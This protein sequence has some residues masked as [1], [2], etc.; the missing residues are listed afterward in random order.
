M[1]GGRPGS[2]SSWPT[3]TMPTSARRRPRPP[4]STPARSAG[5]C[6]A[7]AAT[8]AARI[9]TLDPLVLAALR[10]PEQRAAADIVGYAG[11][12]L[13]PPARRRAGQRPGPARAARPRDPHVPARRGPGHRP[14][15]PLL[16]RRRRQPHRPP[17]RRHG[18][19]RCRLPGRP[20]PDGLPV[21]GEGGPRVAHGPPAVPVLAERTERLGRRARPSGGRST[22]CG[23]TPAR[24]SSPRSST[25]GSAKWT[26]EAGARSASPAAEAFRLIVLDDDEDEGR[27]RRRS[28]CRRRPRRWPRAL[29]R[30]THGPVERF[31]RD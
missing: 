24:S 1:T 19:G 10:E 13:P 9:P 11:H 14:G 5:S 25:R 7:R 23:P 18:R 4:G 16:P 21:A 8:R 12:H 28:R 3:P 30:P 22:P 17:R 2:W 20:Q 31:A 26:A 15:D 29:G 27:R 6:A